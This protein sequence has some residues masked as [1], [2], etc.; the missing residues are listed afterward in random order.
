VFECSAK[1]PVNQLLKS[2]VVDSLYVWNYTRNLI[3]RLKGRE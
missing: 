2:R 3:N 1:L